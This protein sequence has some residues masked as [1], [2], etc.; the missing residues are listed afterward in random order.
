[1]TTTGANIQS[2]IDVLAGAFVN[3]H[4]QKTE[5]LNAIEAFI[6][7]DNI[8][9]TLNQVINDKSLQGEDLN[10]V[11]S[12]IKTN[13]ATYKLIVENNGN[14]ESPMDV[15]VN[16][17]SE[18]HMLLYN[19]ALPI[20]SMFKRATQSGT[21]YITPEG[22]MKLD[23]TGLVPGLPKRQD[24]VIREITTTTNVLI[25][26]RS[27]KF[28][29]NKYVQYRVENP[30]LP[31]E[32]TTNI[33]IEYIDTKT[34]E[35]ERSIDIKISDDDTYK[36]DI[37]FN[38]DNIVITLIH[39]ICVE[40]DGEHTYKITSLNEDQ[41]ITFTCT[42]TKERTTEIL[43]SYKNNTIYLTNITITPLSS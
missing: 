37:V 35:T 7:K 33:L 42:K 39:P 2:Q 30:E 17:G 20:L 11:A 21:Y 28:S 23:D 25:D 9:S 19:G 4:T 5:Q 27:T 24:H 38:Q 18:N 10:F 36:V 8:S 15:N 12:D 26:E 29:K 6:G 14:G 3:E 31:D 1:M 40:T 43:L 16:G 32:P 34:S 13:D 22:I 41:D